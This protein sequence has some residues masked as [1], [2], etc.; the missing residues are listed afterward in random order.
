MK[1]SR[2][3]VLFLFCFQCVAVI[4]D[5]VIEPIS[6]LPN[7]SNTQ[8][9]Q[10]FENQERIKNDAV[11]WGLTVSQYVHYERLMKNTPS[12]HWYKNLDPAEVLALNAS[13][14]NRMMR[15][16]KIQAR[17]MHQRVTRELTFNL[18][19]TRAYQELYPNEKP[20]MPRSSSMSQILQ[21]GDHI[22]LFVGINT[23]LGKLIY[24]HI[25]KII[26]SVPNTTVD[27]YFVGKHL[28]QG[29][30]QE[31]AVNSGIAPAMINNEVTLNYGNTRFQAIANG[32][33]LSLPFV[34]I[35]HKQHF[36]A[37]GLSSL[38]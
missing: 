16:A 20:I 30:V 4:A 15:Y 36:Q 23:P 9:V 33:N 19:Y 14:Q 7:Q 6:T 12:G 26:K 2:V 34:G 8:V 18:L 3:I 1:I 11:M 13:S 31:W 28:S 24:Q 21:S 5:P 25:I 27:I 10:T 17:L 37:I 32:K 22:W 35:V 29:S 38:L